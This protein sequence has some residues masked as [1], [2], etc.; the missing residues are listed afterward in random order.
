MKEFITNRLILSPN[1]M[2]PEKF[3]VRR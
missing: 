1:F 2:P 3:S